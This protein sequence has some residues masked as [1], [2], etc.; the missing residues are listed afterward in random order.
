L[1]IGFLI[2][3]NNKQNINDLLQCVFVVLYL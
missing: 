3:N 1:I 2:K